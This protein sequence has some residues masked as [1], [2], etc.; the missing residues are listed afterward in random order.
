MLITKSPLVLFE[1]SGCFYTIYPSWTL[2]VNPLGYSVS[3]LCHGDLQTTLPH[4]HHQ[5]ELSSVAPASIPYT[6]RWNGQSCFS[7]SHTLRYGLSSLTPPGPSPLC[8]TDE[9]KGL[10]SLLLQLVRGRNSS[11]FSWPEGKLFNLPQVVVGYPSFFF[12]TSFTIYCYCSK[13]CQKVGKTIA[14]CFPMTAAY[15]GAVCTKK[16]SKQGCSF[17]LSS[18]ILQNTECLYSTNRLC[19]IF[20]NMPLLFFLVDKTDNEHSPHSLDI[21]RDL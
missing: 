3:V 2:T 11:P 4:P 15:I 10:L 6:A 1:A 18:R 7:C 9:V 8:C 19:G 17:Q 14:R 12:L 21:V 13:Q 16:T 20:S 5:G